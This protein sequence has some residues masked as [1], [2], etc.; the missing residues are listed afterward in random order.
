MMRRSNAQLRLIEP[1]PE[2]VKAV[3]PSAPQLR[4]LQ[5]LRAGA[6]L[7]YR[8]WPSPGVDLEVGA[9][10]VWV[11]I[12]PSTARILVAREWVKLKAFTAKTGDYRLTPA[13]EAL[14]NLVCEH[15]HFNDDRI[16][17]F[18]RRRVCRD[19]WRAVMN[20]E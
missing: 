19:C 13:G 15:P 3:E 5:F 6:R 20:Y 11:L 8:S 18:D 12:H 10:G 7:V 2:N 9:A 4:A 1:E 14:T 17:V 16:K